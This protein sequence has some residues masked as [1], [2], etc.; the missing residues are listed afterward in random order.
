M[1]WSLLK[2]PTTL[3]GPTK[4]GGHLQALADTS[5]TVSK[6]ASCC[7]FTPYRTGQMRALASI[8]RS[9]KF[10]CSSEAFCFALIH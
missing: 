9:C 8:L 5:L 4:E 3:E 10:M 7:E 2:N 6:A 1:R